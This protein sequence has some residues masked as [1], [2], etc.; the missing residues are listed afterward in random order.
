MYCVHYPNVIFI[1]HDKH[2][3]T[4]GVLH[5]HDYCKVRALKKLNV[6]WYRRCMYIVEHYMYDEMR[7]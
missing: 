2:Y 3:I 4:H 1:P 6:Y 7:S 5:T